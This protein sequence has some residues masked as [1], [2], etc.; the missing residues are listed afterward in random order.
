[1]FRSWF[2]RCRTA[3]AQREDV[4]VVVL[5]AEARGRFAGDRRGPN[6]RHF[7]GRDRHA[8]ARSAKEQ[9]CIERA[10]R[11]LARHP[12]REVRIVN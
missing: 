11:D 9:T 2:V 4:G 12:F 7:V 10:G 3:P 1:M 6:A 5:A 8:D